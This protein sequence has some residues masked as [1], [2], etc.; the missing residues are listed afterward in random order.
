[1]LSFWIMMFIVK[2]LATITASFILK[3]VSKTEWYMNFVTKISNKYISKFIADND[4][5]P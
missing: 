1:M 2:V 5:E 3:L 4:E